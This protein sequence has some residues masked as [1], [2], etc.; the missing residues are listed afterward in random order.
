MYVCQSRQLQLLAFLTV[1]MG[2]ACQQKAGDSS[3]A[4][5]KSEVSINQKQEKGGK[6]GT[7]FVHRGVKQ[8]QTDCNVIIE[9]IRWETKGQ[10]VTAVL[11]KS[12]IQR[13]D[14]IT[15]R[16][17]FPNERLSGPCLLYSSTG[18]SPLLT[19]NVSLL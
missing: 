6:W 18:H 15:Q 12:R 7:S 4:K 2:M 8:T 13:C 17:A 9:K 19:S 11:H 3:Q 10:Q 14:F 5:Y 16:G 1:T